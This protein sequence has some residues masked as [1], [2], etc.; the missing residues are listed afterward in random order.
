MISL[1]VE[2]EEALV[3]EIC[4]VVL[5]TLVFVVNVGQFILVMLNPLRTTSEV[6]RLSEALVFNSFLSS[7]EAL[8]GRSGAVEIISSPASLS[9]RKALLATFEMYP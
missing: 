9:I 2:E 1:L 7:L 8:E 6:R 4:D 3:R 5:V